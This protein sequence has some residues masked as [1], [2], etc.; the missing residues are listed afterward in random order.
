MAQI[1]RAYNLQQKKEINSAF[2]RATMMYDR[3]QQ[4][5]DGMSA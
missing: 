5:E 4:K 1:Q 3:E 2:K